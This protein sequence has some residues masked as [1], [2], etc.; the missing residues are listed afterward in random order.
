MTNSEPTPPN[1]TEAKEIPD[2]ESYTDEKGR[3]RW[4]SNDALAAKLTDLHDILVV[5]GY[6]ASHAA[7]YPKLAL[8]LSRHFESVLHMHRE[9]RL[10]ELPGVGLTIE[11]IL[12]ELIENGTTTKVTEANPESNYAPPPDTIRELLAIP[13]LG[14]RT[15][16]ILWAD[17][18]IGSLEQFA[19]ALAD[20]R[21]KEVKGITPAV[22]KAVKE[23]LTPTAE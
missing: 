8:T 4:R 2:D 12:S 9:K 7:R 15:V 20:G 18:Q 13:R 19:D 6:D 16:R 3:V 11:K 14:A 10:R 17:H 23:R 22:K 1:T 5:G 21:L